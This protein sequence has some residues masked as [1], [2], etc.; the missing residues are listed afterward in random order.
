MLGDRF[1]ELNEEIAAC[2]RC[3]RLVTFREGVVPKKCFQ[4]TYWKK[5]VAGFGDTEA[6]ILLLGLAPAP[7]GGNRTGRIFTGDQSARFLMKALFNTGLSNQNH[8]EHADDGLELRGVYVT[9]SV[10]C[11]PP[12]NR[13]SAL[14]TKNCSAFLQREFL[15]LKRLKVVLALGRHAFEAYLSLAAKRGEL[16]SAAFSHGAFIPFKSLPLLIGS[17]HPSPQNTNRG[18]LTTRMLEEVLERAKRESGWEQFKNK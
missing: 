16:K 15:L 14:E 1:G 8:S 4:E 5:P 18:L 17:Y 10:K 7:H 2:R 13:P 11:V 9:A 12:Q 6:S 3:P